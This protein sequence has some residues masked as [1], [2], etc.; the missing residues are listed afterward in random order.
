MSTAIHRRVEGCRAGN[1]PTV[2]AR[3]RSGWA[4]MG[5]RQMLTGYCLLLPDPVVGTRFY[6]PDEAEADQRERLQAILQA[7]GR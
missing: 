3:L 2:V 4:V 1:D 5:Q 7:R 6:A